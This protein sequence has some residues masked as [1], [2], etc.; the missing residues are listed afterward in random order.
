MIKEIEVK[1]ANSKPFVIKD[2]VI[3]EK[4]YTPLQIRKKFIAGFIGESLILTLIFVVLGKEVGFISAA[5]TVI[6]KIVQ[7]IV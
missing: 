7:K 2:N 6:N 5:S 3:M 1:I 4:G